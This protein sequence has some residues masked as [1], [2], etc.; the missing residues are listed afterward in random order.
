MAENKNKI[1]LSK[2]DRKNLLIAGGI[3]GVIL[4]IGVMGYYALQSAQ[5]TIENVTNPISSVSG[6]G[7]GAGAFKIGTAIATGGISLLIP[8]LSPFY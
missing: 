4:L 2:E 6:T 7:T 5:Q 1:K 8:G 3:G